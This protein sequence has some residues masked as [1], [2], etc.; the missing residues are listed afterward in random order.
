MTE[1]DNSKTVNILKGIA[2]AAVSIIVL[3]ISA[4]ISYIFTKNH[5]GKTK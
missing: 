1:K 2:I 4:A 5:F 3:A